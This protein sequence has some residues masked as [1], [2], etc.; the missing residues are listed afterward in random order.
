MKNLR[1]VIIIHLVLFV[2]IS[3]KLYSQS[4]V[5]TNKTNISTSQ[6]QRTIKGGNIT[7]GSSNG[8]TLKAER[9]AV[10]KSRNEIEF[11]PTIQLT[12]TQFENWASGGDNTF[13]GI[14]SIFFN[15]KYH[16]D[17]QRFY[18][19]YRVSAKYGINVI[20]SE[21]FKNSDQFNINIE[22]SWRLR[23]PWSY[24]IGVNIVSQ[25][26]KGY[27][28]VDDNTIVSNF[29]SPGDID[30]STGIKYEKLPFKITL[31]PLAGKVV[32]VAS[33]S[34]S[35]QGLYGVDA[36]KHSR[37]SL[38]SSVKVDFDKIFAKNRLRLRSYFHA[39]TNYNDVHTARWTNTLDIISTKLLTTTL[40]AE[41]YYDN[42]AITPKKTAMQYN[43]SIGVG[44]SYRFT[45]K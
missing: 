33:D 14:A 3:P 29:M 26:T 27:K 6:S 25:F 21:S 37:E 30:L 13:S 32:V 44:F 7:P 45:N 5:P 10:R 1:W 28:S 31:S 38:G 18:L 12:Q 24:A 41:L 42:L 40:Y 20:N 16:K 11:S 36:G 22:P 35:N 15:H 23:G 19:E 8:A 39:F 34:I 9:R 43:Y 2:C 17:N 4:P